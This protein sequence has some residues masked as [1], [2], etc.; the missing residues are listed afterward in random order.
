MQKSWQPNL[1][2][3]NWLERGRKGQLGVLIYAEK[4]MNPSEGLLA[5]LLYS[6]RV[7]DAADGL[8]VYLAADCCVLFLGS[9]SNS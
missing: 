3:K 8:S 1:G 2:V 4:S 5:A 6:C 9:F 7:A